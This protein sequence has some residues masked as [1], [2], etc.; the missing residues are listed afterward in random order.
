MLQG[1]A[2]V[3]LDWGSFNS[4]VRC[5][6]FGVAQFTKSPQYTQSQAKSSGFLLFQSFGA[7]ANVLRLTKMASALATSLPAQLKGIK[8]YI[9]RGAEVEKY[10]LTAHVPEQRRVAYYC[11][12]HAMEKAVESAHSSDPAVR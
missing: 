7:S 4:G 11:L 12:M 8:P 9:L 3:K 1:P 10:A 6:R 5:K 2:Q